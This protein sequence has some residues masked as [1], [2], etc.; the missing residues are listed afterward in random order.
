MDVTDTN[1]NLSNDNYDSAFAKTELVSAETDQ[2]N[3]V[4]DIGI[5]EDRFHG[6]TAE[7]IM[8]DNMI[9]PT[10]EAQNDERLMDVDDLLEFDDLD[11]VLLT[12]AESSG[13]L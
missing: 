8:T 1:Y 4:F 6:L 12:M 2:P 9:L 7:M 3:H 10:N 5:D 11:S 13:E